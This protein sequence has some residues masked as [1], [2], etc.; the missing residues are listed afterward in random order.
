MDTMKGEINLM[1]KE[2]I[3]E[4]TGAASVSR[5][6]RIKE[7]LHKVCHQYVVDVKGVLPDEAQRGSDSKTMEQFIKS[8]QRKCDSDHIRR[9][10]RFVS[11]LLKMCLLPFYQ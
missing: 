6:E 9:Q 8:L 5:S 7:A 10:E 3:P 1:L 11:I 2:A 4:A